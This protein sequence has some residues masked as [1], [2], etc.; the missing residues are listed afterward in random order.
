MKTE[1]EITDRIRIWG[2]SL[3]DARKRNDW[4]LCIEIEREIMAW[5]RV[6]E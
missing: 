2:E 6:I 5:E 3:K 4:S 1:K